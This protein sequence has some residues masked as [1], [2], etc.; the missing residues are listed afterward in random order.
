MNGLALD[1]IPD[2]GFASS[3]VGPAVF[4][5]RNRTIDLTLTLSELVSAGAVT[6]SIETAASPQASTWRTV[7]TAAPLSALGSII[8][9]PTGCA[10]FIRARYAVSV[11]GNLSFSLSGSAS[12]VLL[13]PGTV[14]ASGASTPVDVGQYR[15]ARLLVDVSA[16][17]GSAATLVAYIETAASATATTWRQVGT[18]INGG[19]VSAQAISVSDFDR[20]VRVRYV[21]GGTAPSF[22]IAVTGESVFVLASPRDR[23]RIGVRGGAIPNA[24]PTDTVEA[25]I[26]ATDIALGYLGGRFALP[27]R[28]WGDD[29]RRACIAIAD[30]TLLSNRGGEPDKA[31]GG[32]LYRIAYEDVM[33]RPGQKGWLDKVAARDGIVPAGLVDSTQP[34]TEGEIG[35]ITVL[36]LPLR[37]WG[38]RRSRS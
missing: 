30:W 29:L 5:G 25:M 21:V 26:A 19:V 17:S 18:P 1:L 38:G 23:T 7:T 32:E 27:L 14:T 13:A 22:D 11:G 20:F 31:G 16:A 36:S 35:R 9:T 2:S 12:L 15:A 34:T 28:A 3:G 6:V 33:G 37:G 4:I 8:I 24:T 10:D